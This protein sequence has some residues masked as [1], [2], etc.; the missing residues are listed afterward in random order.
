VLLAVGALALAG[1]AGTGTP[2]SSGSDNPVGDACGTVPA[3]APNDPSG[4]VAGLS[5]DLQA[6]YNAYPLEVQESAWADFTS[7]K[8]SGWKAAIVGMPP[9]NP[10]IGQLQGAIKADLEA[11]GFDIVADFAPDVVSN[12][13][14]QIQQLQEAIALKPDVI[15]YVPI[16]PEPALETVK[17]AYDAGIPVISTQIA[18]DTPYAVSVAMNA[19]AQAMITG[20]GVLKAAGGEG[21]VLHVTGIPGLGT[22]IDGEAG[23]S[24]VLDL[25]PNVTLAGEAPGAFNPATAQA[26]VLKFLATHPAGVD[27][28]FQDGTMGL[29]ALNAFLESGVD[30]VPP[31]TDT[32]GS[33]GFASWALQNPDYAYFGSTT[34]AGQQAAAT[35]SV[36]KRI[37]AGGGPKMNQIA[38]APLIVDRENLA[39]IADPS[40]PI[41]DMT[42][43]ENPPDTLLTPSQLDE[44]FT[45]PSAGK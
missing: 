35:V 13:P 1:C 38:Y 25:C 10:F 39:D 3:I 36:G 18:L 16:A 37:L 2:D 9:A 23:F 14:L 32:G 5:E 19:V 11:E 4:L 33:Q 21:E 40:W 42:Q 43:L 30:P 24:N 27:M 29:P 22:T 34:S 7:P 6:A 41:T 45:N 20:A 8:T 28:V 15:F 12:V 31:I 26:E 44:F 17:S